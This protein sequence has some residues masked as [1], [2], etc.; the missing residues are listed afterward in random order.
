MV[1]TVDTDEPAAG[2][3]FCDLFGKTSSAEALAR[4]M[5]WGIVEMN[6][7]DQRTGEAIRNV[8]L[9]ASYFNTF[10][11]DGNFMSVKDGGMKLA[12]LDEADSLFGN[13]DRGAMPVINEL[14]KCAR[15]PVS[16]IVNDFY[17]LSRKSSA[18]KTETVQIPFRKPTASATRSRITDAAC[19]LT[20]SS[21][22]V[23][24]TALAANITLLVTSLLWISLSL[25]ATAPSVIIF[26]TAVSR[27]RKS[28]PTACCWSSSLPDCVSLIR[29]PIPSSSFGRIT[30]R[31]SPTVL[32][33]ENSVA[34]RRPSRIR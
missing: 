5:G 26:P 21:G 3:T 31:A 6:A 18:V 9:R 17:E 15:Q 19:V 4:D 34:R 16:L 28:S 33:Q 29:R 13:A 24:A 7:S 1:V 11:D 14:I 23:T 22:S 20:A 8:A 32:L 27:W 25:M 10:D 2:E 12:V 30:R